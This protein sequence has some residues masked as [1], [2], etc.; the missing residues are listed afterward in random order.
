MA[1]SD[2][3]V[4]DAFVR[5]GGQCECTRLCLEHA[6]KGRCPRRLAPFGR[7]FGLWQAHHIVSQEAGGADSLSNCQLLCTECHQKT[8]SY[9]AKL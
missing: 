7:L 2:S 9:G 4:N 3:V 6:L 8:R 5:S 1:F